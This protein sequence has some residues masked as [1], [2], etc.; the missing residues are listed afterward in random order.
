VRRRDFITALGGAAAI[1]FVANAQQ[2]ERM[3]RIGVRIGVSET[4]PDHQS[5]MAAFRQELQKLGWTD[6]RNVRIDVRGASATNADRLRTD[7]AELL[8]L[9]PDVILSAGGS[10]TVEALQRATSTIPIVFVGVIDPVGAG[11]VASLARPGG[12]T[13]GFTPFEYAISTK[14]LELLKEID[15][16][17]T[18]AAVLRDPTNPSGIG[19]WAAM[20]GVAPSLGVELSPIGVRDTSEIERAIAAFARDSNGGLIV[21][22][23][24]LT[25]KHRDLIGALAARHR[26]AAVY[27][28]RYFV[29]GGG[30]ISYGPDQLGQFRQAVGYVDR[31]LKGEKPADL[32]VQ[33]ITKIEL[34]INLKTAKSLGITVPL[35]LLARADEVIE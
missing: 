2:P 14:W 6:G 22:L 25:I 27:P 29:A 12:N 16:R 1:P 4:D 18:R 35:S 10:L 23:G 15:P 9:A 13:T 24:G 17:V 26:L 8:A 28:Y 3:R 30:L 21:T 5:R 7:V 20:Q 31:I 11:F 19:Q 32:P 33:Q 34:V